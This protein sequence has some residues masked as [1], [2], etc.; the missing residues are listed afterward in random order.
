MRRHPDGKLDTLAEMDF[1]ADHPVWWTIDGRRNIIIHKKD[2]VEV[3]DMVT[4]QII[5]PESN[6][7]GPIISSDGQW[8]VQNS[9]GATIRIVKTR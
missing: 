4:G 8:M 1:S 2:T 6:Q 9:P 3:Q 7:N 5:A